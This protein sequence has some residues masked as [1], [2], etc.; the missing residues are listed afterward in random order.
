MFKTVLTLL[1]LILLVAGCGQQDVGPDFFGND[2]EPVK[3]RTD[4]EA[5]PA[6]DLTVKDAG[7]AMDS[8]NKDLEQ[9]SYFPFS[10]VL[11]FKVIT[12]VT[13]DSILV[14]DI[15][16]KIVKSTKVVN[17]YDE[18]LTIDNL[19]PGDLIKLHS[20]GI[21]DENTYPRKSYAKIVKL[22]TDKE[23][24]QV[25][26]AIRHF[27]E[28][29]EGGLMTG[30]WISGV[31]NEWIHL[32]FYD[33]SVEKQYAAT[34]NLLTNEYSVREISSVAKEREAGGN[35]VDNGHISEIYDNGFRVMMA[36]YTLTKD[37][38][39]ETD[40]GEIITKD[41]L[42]IG[43]FVKVD[44]REYKGDGIIK[45]AKLNKLTLLKSEEKPGVQEWVKS[46]LEGPLY[47]DP[48]IMFNYI[49]RSGESYT[50]RVADLQDDT[51]DTFEVTYDFNTKKQS[52]ERIEH[53][54]PNNEPTPYDDINDYQIVQ[55]VGKDSVFMGNS[56]KY[57]DEDL[58]ETIDGENISIQDLKVGSLIKD[59]YKQINAEHGV[60][61]KIVWR[62]DELYENISASI[63]HFI[64]NQQE[65]PIHSIYIYSVDDETIVLKFRKDK[66]E[67]QF[68]AKIDRKTN[69]FEVEEER[70]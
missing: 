65:G 4:K 19:R 33:I 37:S 44:Y 51:W 25:S 17:S 70:Y 23:S 9:P 31:G 10:K 7:P 58:L 40:S 60:L 11:D 69:T 47:K 59:E 14:D 55:G 45:E 61:S 13:D 30:T 36:D 28:N 38:V 48:V 26:H 43:D 1:I 8:K 21:I 15:Y 35:G 52:I 67:N 57:L 16:Y 56:Y 27:I 18:K 5:G 54:P 24:I 12:D 46:V 32:R 53:I 22:Q 62:N 2:T 42:K 41:S 66:K 64:E 20:T 6:D 49:G 68:K 50:I 34:I 3:E 29:R 39:L 63:R